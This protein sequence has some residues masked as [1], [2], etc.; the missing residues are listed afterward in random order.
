[1][2]VSHDMNAVKILC[3][4]AILLEKGHKVEEGDPEGVINTYNFLLAKKAKNET[5]SLVRAGTRQDYGNGKV[6]ISGVEL[7]DGKGA[8][9][10]VLVA[11]RPC[12][13]RIVLHG[14][15]D[16]D[17]VTIGIALR[18]RF[19]QDVFG[20]NSCFLQKPISICKG[21][22]RVV[23]FSFQQ[24]NIGAGKYTLTVAGH[25]GEAHLDDCYHWIDGA[26]S[27]EVVLD[28]DFFFLGLARLEPVLS[29]ENV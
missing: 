3:D 24:L 5:L 12:T 29:I 15:A 27:F 7:L 19:G 4:R 8:R 13:I 11:G 18:D 28:A 6:E 23:S 2:F 26:V 14:H 25:S 21:E 9:A 20:T 22:E 17:N 10:E 16:V 1:M